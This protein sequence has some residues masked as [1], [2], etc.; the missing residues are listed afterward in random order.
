MDKKI[1]SN[2]KLFSHQL[3]D[4]LIEL[5]EAADQ[6]ILVLSMKRNKEHLTTSLTK[7]DLYILAEFLKL[8]GI[9]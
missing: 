9:K 4:S 6:D 7:A 1:S 5:R 3:G 8:R 2:E